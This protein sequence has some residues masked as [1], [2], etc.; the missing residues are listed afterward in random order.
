MARARSACSCSAAD[1]ASM[2]AKRFV[3]LA[4]HTS[5]TSTASSTT[6]HTM[7]A[8]S[9][10]VT[11]SRSETCD[12]CSDDDTRDGNGVAAAAVRLR[13]LGGLAA[14]Q[15]GAAVRGP[16]RRHAQV[17]VFGQRREQLRH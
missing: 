5:S 7:S 11:G 3:D 8:R 13:H 9:S 1:S 6:T 16:H 2:T 4:H 17:K 12:S 15:V 10:G 14:G